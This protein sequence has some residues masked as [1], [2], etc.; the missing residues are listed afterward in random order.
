M[1]RRELLTLADRVQ[2][3]SALLVAD[4]QREDEAAAVLEDKKNHVIDS[5]RYGVEP[6]RKPR[7]S[8]VF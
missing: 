3:S 5:A 6:I 7:R 2:M 1:T 8:V 4:L